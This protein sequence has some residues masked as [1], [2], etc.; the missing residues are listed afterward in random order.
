VTQQRAETDAQW[1]ELSE[2]ADYPEAAQDDAGAS[3]TLQR[4]G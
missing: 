1:R 2:S 4:N 3:L